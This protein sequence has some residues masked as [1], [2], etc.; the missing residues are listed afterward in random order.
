MAVP[1]NFLAYFQYGKQTW[2][3]NKAYK[4]IEEEL[5]TDGYTIS[6]NF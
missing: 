5:S 1:D 2:Y 6:C 4:N 3:D